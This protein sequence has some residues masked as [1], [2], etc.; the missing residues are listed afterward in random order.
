MA[1]DFSSICKTIRELVI[2]T[3]DISEVSYHI[4]YLKKELA[5]KEYAD[6]QNKLIPIIDNIQRIEEEQSLNVFTQCS[7]VVEQIQQL[8]GICREEP[9]NFVALSLLGYLTLKYGDGIESSLEYQETGCALLEKALEINKDFAFAHFILAREYIRRKLPNDV[10]LKKQAI[11]KIVQ[12]LSNAAAEGY[13]PALFLCGQY[14]IDA[15]GNNHCLFK[16][17]KQI[18]QWIR[19][20]A[21]DPNKY[22]PAKFLY[23]LGQK[24]EDSDAEIKERVECLKEV[25]ASGHQE[26]QYLLAECFATGRGI[27]KDIKQA[28]YWYQCCIE[29]RQG[30]IPLLRSAAKFNIA[31]IHYEQTNFKLSWNFYTDTARDILEY[32]EKSLEA[33]IRWGQGGIGCYVGWKYVCLSTMHIIS[34]KKIILINARSKISSPD[35]ADLPLCYGFKEDPGDEGKGKKEEDTLILHKPNHDASDHGCEFFND[36][37]F[38]LV[39][40][41]LAKDRTITT[42]SVCPTNHEQYQALSR[43]LQKNNV[44]KKLVFH[45]GPLPL[46]RD[47]LSNFFQKLCTNPSIEE[48]QFGTQFLDSK[49]GLEIR[50]IL[51]MP[52]LRTIYLPG[53][54]IGPVAGGTILSALDFNERIGEIELFNCNLHRREGGWDRII[55]N[56]LQARQNQTRASN[57]PQDAALTVVHPTPTTRVSEETSAAGGRSVKAGEIKPETKTQV[58]HLIQA[59]G[60]GHPESQYLLAEYLAMQSD[61]SQ[62]IPQAISWYQ[63]CIDNQS[64]SKSPLS[65]VA[66]FKMAEIYYKIGKYDF[67]RELFIKVITDC[68]RYYRDNLFTIRQLNDEGIQPQV[69]I[70]SK[71]ESFAAMCATSKKKIILMNAKAKIAIPEFAN[72]PLCRGFK[73][74]LPEEHTNNVTENNENKEKKEEDEL[75]LQLY[76]G[77][78]HLLAGCAPIDDAEFKIIMEAL[79]KDT[80]ITTLRVNPTSAQQFEALSL[81]LEQNKFLKVLCLSRVDN[82]PLPLTRE[83]LSKFLQR[84]CTNQSI[85]IL[86]WDRF[87]KY[88]EGLEIRRVFKMPKLRALNISNSFFPI[89]D[90]E[91]ESWIANMIGGTILHCLDFNQT[92]QEIYIDNVSA[93]CQEEIQ[94]A[95]KR[96]ADI[97]KKR[98][99]RVAC[100]MAA[101]H[102]EAGKK[103]YLHEL[104]QNPLFD[105]SLLKLCWSFTD[106][107]DSFDDKSHD[108]VPVLFSAPLKMTGT[109]ASLAIGPG[110]GPGPGLDPAAGARTTAGAGASAAAGAGAPAAAGGPII[111]VIGTAALAAAAHPLAGAGPIADIDPNQDLNPVIQQ[112]IANSLASARR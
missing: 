46:T 10:D 87:F 98:A 7:I 91:N 105:Q 20:A 42:L 28:I 19:I 57:G 95:L 9:N 15:N 27:T 65:I 106:F 73:N 94:R 93:D 82:N 17:E 34:K 67:A 77:Y 58:E 62:D 22:L 5:K 39:M 92:I 70:G 96:N 43:C 40:E 50:K 30:K 112:V 103:S 6:V 66:K 37:E 81:A 109:V 35:C 14:D 86:D 32:R 100:V 45:Q 108:S 80:S 54:H 79:A 85:E 13:L 47:Q 53:N 12:L 31:E 60:S 23:F 90:L 21:L 84:L 72:L 59:A 2:R 36:S 4:N 76:H 101:K 49:S 64:T 41:A 75:N 97:Q 1:T 38:R 29:N 107:G 83:Q 56:V 16:N 18:R 61:V 78:S 3:D 102:P 25:A 52:N 69:M 63:K 55:R 89:S 24:N 110:P 104:F 74:E 88:E 68:Q 99:Q 51:G 8:Q 71:S 26:S 111:G 48:I 11:Q 44:L 33:S